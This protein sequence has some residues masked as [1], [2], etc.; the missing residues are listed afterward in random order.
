MFFEPD[1]L[2]EP[3]RHGH[4]KLEN[5]IETISSWI[6]LGDDS[7]TFFVVLLWTCF[8]KRFIIEKIKPFFKCCKVVIYIFLYLKV[9]RYK[10]VFYCWN[11]ET[12]HRR[13]IFCPISHVRIWI[14][15]GHALCLHNIVKSFTLLY[16]LIWKGGIKI[17]S[18]SFF[19]AAHNRDCKGKVAWCEYLVM[20][21]MLS[22][23]TWIN[24][25]HFLLA[26]ASLKNMYALLCLVWSL[27]LCLDC[28]TSSSTSFARLL[29]QDKG[30]VQIVW[31]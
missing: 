7:I 22:F 10:T 18:F 29:Q 16:C 28:R 26:R 3:T 30:F 12:L 5:D 24:I 9:P 21:T 8:W 19:L 14:N 1:T 27:L 25:S 31:S 23:H 6:S 15:Q 4:Y 17:Q 20:H 13:S 2:Q 11:L